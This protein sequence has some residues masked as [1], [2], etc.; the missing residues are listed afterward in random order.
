MSITRLFDRRA[1][2]AAA[3]E[4][5][6]AGKARDPIATA[7]EFDAEVPSREPQRVQLPLTELVESPGWQN[8]KYSQRLGL[9]LGMLIGA[10]VPIQLVR[11]PGVG[12]ACKVAA[13]VA[14]LVITCAGL[15]WLVVD[16]IEIARPLVVAPVTR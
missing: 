13:L 2:I 9:S 1:Q 3:K 15:T 14:L 10:F 12:A 7:Q 4:R 8:L 6:P 16:A 5:H 11:R